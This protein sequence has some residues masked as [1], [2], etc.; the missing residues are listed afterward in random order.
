MSYAVHPVEATDPPERVGRL[1]EQVRAGGVFVL[2]GAGLST[3]SGIPDYRGRDGVRRV[4]PMQYAEFAGSS[5]ARRR[6][7]SSMAA[8]T[9]AA[10]GTGSPKS[11]AIGIISSPPICAVMATAPGR[12]TAITRWTPL[13]MTSLS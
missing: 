7:C 11:C 1:V 6:Y 13:S 3:D 4:M 2:T 5:A 8:G 9:I 10:T 12:P